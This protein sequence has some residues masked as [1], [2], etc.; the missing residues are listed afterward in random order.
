LIL[1]TPSKVNGCLQFIH[2]CMWPNF[3]MR[4]KLCIASHLLI[5]EE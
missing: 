5:H 4:E 1:P 2:L 3:A